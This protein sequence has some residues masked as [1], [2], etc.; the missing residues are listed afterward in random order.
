MMDFG[1]LLADPPRGVRVDL[2]PEGSVTIHHQPTGMGCI[3]AFFVVWITGWTIG[4]I[5][6]KWENGEPVQG[7]ERAL[8]IAVDILMAALATYLGLTTRTFTLREDTLILETNWIG[9]KWRRRVERSHVKSVKQIQEGGLDEDSFPSWGL[10]IGA[11]KKH[12]LLVRQPYSTSL[13][14]GRILGN[15]SGVALEVATPP[16]NTLKAK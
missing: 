16:P 15:W 13:W 7:R 4:L 3:N 8:F 5:A 11:A 10:E 14:L 12:H 9:M 6:G 1:E 2:L